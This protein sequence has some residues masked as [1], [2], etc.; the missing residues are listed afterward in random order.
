MPAYSYVHCG[1]PIYGEG[2][3]GEGRRG[4]CGALASASAMAVV[5]WYGGV[6]WCMVVYGVVASKL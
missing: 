6:W 5:V 3:E 2:R 4:V 1:H